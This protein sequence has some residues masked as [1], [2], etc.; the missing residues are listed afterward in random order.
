MSPTRSD[1]T[2]TPFNI[3]AS[4][5]VSRTLTKFV[6]ATID[7]MLAEMGNVCLDVE[8]WISTFAEDVSNRYNARSVPQAR[9]PRA[10]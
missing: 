2:S 6:I 4:F 1:D 9:T 8:G 10:E 7:L 5:L 3:A